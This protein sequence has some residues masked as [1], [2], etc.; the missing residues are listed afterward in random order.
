MSFN[1]ERKKIEGEGGL[2]AVNLGGPTVKF[3]RIFNSYG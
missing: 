3:N 1:G 2:L